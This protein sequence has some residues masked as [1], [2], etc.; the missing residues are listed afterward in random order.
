MPKSNLC[1]NLEAKRY[2]YLAGILAG[3]MRQQ[4]LSTTDISR[5]TGIPERTVTDRL[6]HPEKMRICDMYKL[7]DVTGIR[8]MFAFK[9]VPE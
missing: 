4:N 9:D 5:R 7:C 2:D 3:G 8:I 6:L 1:E